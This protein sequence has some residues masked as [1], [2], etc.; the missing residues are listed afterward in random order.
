[1]LGHGGDGRP[2]EEGSAEDGERLIHARTDA[3][4]RKKGAPGY[5]LYGK[6]GELT[7]PLTSKK[8]LH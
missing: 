1:M 4:S 7:L 6:E 8:V 5:H 3:R 2:G